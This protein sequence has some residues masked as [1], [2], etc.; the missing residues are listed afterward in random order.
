M[1]ELAQGLDID[2]NEPIRGIE[3]D[4]NDPAAG[5]HDSE[6]DFLQSRQAA[7]EVTLTD[8]IDWEELHEYAYQFTADVHWGENDGEFSSCLLRI[9][10][11]S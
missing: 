5:L 11:F 10:S 1:T 3:I 8:P 7:V 2:L 6:D 9:F 4:L